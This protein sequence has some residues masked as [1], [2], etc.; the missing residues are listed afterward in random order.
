MVSKESIDIFSKQVKFT[1]D[2]LKDLPELQ[3]DFVSKKGTVV[4]YDENLA[5][6]MF[7]KVKLPEDLNCRVA[8]WN[9]VKRNIDATPINEDIEYA[10]QN[11]LEFY[12]DTGFVDGDK[13]KFWSVFKG[14]KSGGFNTKKGYAKIIQNE[15]KNRGV[16][17]KNNDVSLISCFAYASDNK[18]LE[19]VHTGVM[20]NTEDG[21]LIIE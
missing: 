18:W 20:V 8:A 11:I 12:P 4:G 3:E 19:A 2:F 16:S 14:I 21:I 15:W 9:L 13:E 17:F 6:N 5:F 7:I 10:E 1:N